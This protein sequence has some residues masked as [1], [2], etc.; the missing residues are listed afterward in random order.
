LLTEGILAKA[1]GMSDSRDIS[2]DR[3]LTDVTG[4]VTKSPQNAD[5]VLRVN[6][7][8]RMLAETVLVD[9]QQPSNNQKDIHRE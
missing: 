6:R 9:Q 2:T 5:C 4:L 7:F 1:I 8:H 3:V